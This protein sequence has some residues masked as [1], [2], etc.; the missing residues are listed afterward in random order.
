MGGA[1][2]R[3]QRVA[4]TG[5]VVICVVFSLLLEKIM[6]SIKNSV[7]GIFILW[8][9]SSAALG[10]VFSPYTLIT[11]LIGEPNGYKIGWPQWYLLF[12][13]VIDL[14]LIGASVTD[15]DYHDDV[16]KRASRDSKLLSG[17]C[18]D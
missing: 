5:R 4:A 10:L 3:E 15:H 16:A 11:F 9:M 14:C 7:Q 17:G 13:L 2:D 8:F 18:D 6:I 1:E 12:F